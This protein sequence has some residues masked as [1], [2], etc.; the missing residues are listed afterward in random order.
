MKLAPAMVFSTDYEYLLP[1]RWTALMSG[2]IN[3]DI[4]ASTGIHTANEAIKMLL[5]GAKNV[6]VVSAL[7]K[8]GRM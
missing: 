4:S 2:R 1:L 6:Q 8:H 7:Y 5:A 3:I